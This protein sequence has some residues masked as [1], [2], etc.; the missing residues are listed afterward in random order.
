MHFS[1][2]KIV[3]MEWLPSLILAQCRILPYSWAIRTRKSGVS[4]NEYGNAP[5]IKSITTEILKN[6]LTQ[7]DVLIVILQ[8]K[9]SQQ[10]FDFL[11][12]SYSNS[13]KLRQDIE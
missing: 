8:I 3:E 4:P 1:G 13:S 2:N 5:K 7:L 11:S 6:E 12:P 10:T 9:N